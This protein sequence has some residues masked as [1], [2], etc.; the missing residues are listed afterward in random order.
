MK[1]SVNTVVDV[2]N[3]VVNLERM[4]FAWTYNQSDVLS[5]RIPGSYG[6]AV[7]VQLV[8]GID[9]NDPLERARFEVTLPHQCDGF[10]I[11][12]HEE[13]VA[14]VR[15]LMQAFIKETRDAGQ[16]LMRA[17]GAVVYKERS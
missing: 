7:E 2:G 17:T 1:S 12:H 13:D 4:G 10:E 15:E 5:K 6:F 3:S 11:L 9:H 14:A 16:W 8:E